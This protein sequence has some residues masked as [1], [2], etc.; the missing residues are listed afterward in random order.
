MPTLLV[1]PRIAR[2]FGAE[3]RAAG[4]PGLHLAVVDAAMPLSP[5]QLEEVDVA[6]VSLDVIGLST[7]TVLTPYMRL[8]CEQLLG[9]PRLRWMHIPSAG[10]DRP[11]FQELLRRGVRVTTSSGA[12]AQ[13]VAH[14]ALMG[15][16]L[17]GRGGLHWI[18]A[19]RAHQWAP[20]RGAEAPPDLAGQTA[21]V[22]G[23]GPI[24][25]SI[26]QL[27]RTLGLRVH[28][29][30]HRPQPGDAGQQIHGYAAL[31][32]LAR[33]AHWLVL[34]CPLTE[35]TRRLVD[36]RVLNAMPR[37]GRVVNVGRGGVLDEA[38][39]LAALESGQISGAHLDV[40]EQEPLPP[41]SAF[42]ARP[43]VLVTPHN[44]GSSAGYADR[45]VHLF[46]D[47]LAR[48]TRAEPLL[49][50]VAGDLRLPLPPR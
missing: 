6:L 9:A 48:W 21:I 8:F 17:L 12:N 43:D 26:A 10:V 3:L 15:V 44:A 29:L 50:E 36:A 33:E 30:R 5:G 37:G 13:A 46:L 11:V 27:L 31:G 49:Q 35:A 25:R 1:S 42:W 40:F 2:D 20:L 45:C 7:K 41:G 28:G 22:V 23:Q 32:E 19:Q 47:N 16:L 4:G 18:Q 39:L 24:G 34:A 38:A 14:T